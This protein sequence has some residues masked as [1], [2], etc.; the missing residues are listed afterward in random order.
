MGSLKTSKKPPPKPRPA[1]P[2]PKRRPITSEPGRATVWDRIVVKEAR[3]SLHYKMPPTD[4]A[5][6]PL[7]DRTFEV[8]ATTGDLDRDKDRIRP[9]GWDTTEYQRKPVIMYGTITSPCPL[10]AAPSCLPEAMV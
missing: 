1:P 2:P 9:D 8:V 7:G 3:M 5:P 6:V 4:G 10:P